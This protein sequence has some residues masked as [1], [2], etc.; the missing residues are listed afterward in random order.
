MNRIKQVF[1][2]RLGSGYDHTELQVSE[3]QEEGVVQ[4]SMKDGSLDLYTELDLTTAIKFC[5]D[6]R[7]SI[8]NAKC[9]SL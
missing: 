6:L 8:D 5:K 9:N 2:G 4:V 1:L 7:K 3:T